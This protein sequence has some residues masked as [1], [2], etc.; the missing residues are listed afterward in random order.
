MSTYRPP[1][2]STPTHLRTIMQLIA[3]RWVTSTADPAGKWFPSSSFPRLV[4]R[5][6]RPIDAARA[7][8]SSFRLSCGGRQVGFAGS[9][10]PCQL[11]GT[12]LL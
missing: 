7:S 9:E 6:K 2:A 5:S 12:L 10:G 8:L 4:F 11:V 3:G 1:P